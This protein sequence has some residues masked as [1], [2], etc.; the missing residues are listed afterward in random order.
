MIESFNPLPPPKRGETPT[1]WRFSGDG[2][3]VSIHSP[4]RSEGRLILANHVIVQHEFQSTPPAEARGDDRRRTPIKCNRKLFQS[5]PPA[6]ARGDCRQTK[7]RRSHQAVSIHS[8]RRSEGRH[9]VR[10]TSPAVIRSFNP[11]PPPKR[12]ETRVAQTDRR[13]RTSFNPLPPPKRGETLDLPWFAIPIE[14]SIHSPR[15]SEGRRRR[16]PRPMRHRP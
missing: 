11:L 7:V 1:K 12:G 8:P 2:Y 13:A 15:R 5:T 16:Q 4:R 9:P 14:V 3:R 10:R 6:E